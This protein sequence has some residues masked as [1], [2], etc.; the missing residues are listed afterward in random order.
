[1]AD[2]EGILVRSLMENDPDDF[3][4]LH[5]RDPNP[6]SH[7]GKTYSQSTTQT[8]FGW[9]NLSFMSQVKP[10]GGTVKSFPTMVYEIISDVGSEREAAERWFGHINRELVHFT[11]DGDDVANI[12]RPYTQTPYTPEP[13]YILVAG[14]AGSPSSTGLTV[15][16]FRS[17]GLKADQ[18]SSPEKGRRT[19]AVEIDG[20]W[21]YHNVHLSCILANPVKKPAGGLPRPVPA[22]QRGQDE[23]P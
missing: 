3:E 15:S 4:F 7:G 5:Q 23:R 10:P 6:R 17:L 18:L 19:G 16:A 13:G 14:E 22:R 9:R 20:E 11:G 21:W 1:M 2:G 8:S 12:F